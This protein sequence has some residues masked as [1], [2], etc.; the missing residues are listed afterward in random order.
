M[1]CSRWVINSAGLCSK[2]RAA[3]GGIPEVPQIGT[4]GNITCWIK[5]PGLLKTPVYPAPNDQGGFRDP[6][7]AYGG[8]EYPGGGRTGIPRRDR[9]IM[10]TSS[11][12]WTGCSR[13]AGKCSKKWN[14]SIFI[15][16]FVGI[17]WRN[18]DPVTKEPLDFRIMTDPSIPHT[19]SLVGI[20]SPGVTGSTASG[21]ES[22]Q[23]FLWENRRTKAG[24][25][26]KAGL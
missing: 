6:C 16:N 13:M 24:L 25:L 7:H 23:L 11:R 12:A 20:E 8:R 2:N 17:R 15:R 1:V 22:K 4:K 3:D 26:P 18:C 21:P 5:R 19:V 10:P 14:G 9:K